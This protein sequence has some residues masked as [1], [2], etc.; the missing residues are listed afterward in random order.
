MATRL[1]SIV[2][3]PHVSHIK[4]DITLN[5]NLHILTYIGLNSNPYDS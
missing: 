5:T 2:I 4:G 1:L 3:I